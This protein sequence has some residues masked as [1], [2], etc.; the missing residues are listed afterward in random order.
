[1]INQQVIFVDIPIHMTKVSDSS[2]LRD[3]AKGR[4]VG[5]MPSPPPKF[6]NTCMYI[7]VSDIVHSLA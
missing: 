7:Q 3:E 6:Y 1:M 4:P 5:A 2:K